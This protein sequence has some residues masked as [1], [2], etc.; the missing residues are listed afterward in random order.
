MPSTISA[1]SPNKKRRR[2][3]KTVT[4]TPLAL[5][6]VTA[7]VAPE[8]AL[9]FLDALQS[10]PEQTA[11]QPV[12]ASPPT[13]LTGATTQE[14]LPD[15]RET[16]L[17]ESSDPD[18]EIIFA[19]DAELAHAELLLEK[20]KLAL[21]ARS[22]AL[23]AAQDVF[24]KQLRIKEIHQEL[25]AS[26][27]KMAQV[28]SAEAE[29]LASAQAKAKE[30]KEF[31]A[32]QVAAAALLASQ[33]KSR[34]EAEATK[35]QKELLG[36]AQR[37]GAESVNSPGKS[38]DQKAPVN[39]NNSIINS[40]MNGLVDDSVGKTIVNP[41]SV[42]PLNAKDLPD[43]LT[44]VIKSA[45]ET[46]EDKNPP[47]VVKETTIPAPAVKE[48]TIP[49]PVN[50]SGPALPATVTNPDIFKAGLA[51]KQDVLF[52]SDKAILSDFVAVEAAFVSIELADCLV[53]QFKAGNSVVQSRL[54]KVRGLSNIPKDLLSVE[55]KLA[56]LTA[57]FCCSTLFQR[58]MN[59]PRALAS[60]NCFL[61]V[62]R[63]HFSW[64]DETSSGHK[65]PPL[66]PFP[67][68]LSGRDL[69]ILF[70]QFIM[71]INCIDVVFGISLSLL[72]KTADEILVLGHS[73]LLVAKYIDDIRQS[74]FANE[75]VTLMW[76]FQDAVFT[77]S[78]NSLAA[79]MPGLIP[80]A[81]VA[82]V[83]PVVIPE[84][85]DFMARRRLNG[86]GRGRQVSAL[87]TEVAHVR[88]PSLR[89]GSIDPNQ[90]WWACNDFND[91]S[92]CGFPSN[93]CKYHH[94]C[95][96]CADPN[97]GLSTHGMVNPKGVTFETQK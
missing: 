10:L 77:Q 96:A 72:Y 30:V 92:G 81:A 87:P 14:N 73:P 34:L 63:G 79:S 29:F 2:N 44:P 43:G 16:T 56:K 25:L 12:V 23:S 42:T 51:T 86:K 9:K 54:T 80:K 89:N 68:N 75:N 15:Q 13:G 52:L 27:A 5:P 53:T 84:V 57:S 4:G 50:G 59:N 20:A 41:G 70:H 47:P 93:V 49:A 8:E 76:S 32:S 61:A 83:I 69:L 26:Q 71:L 33:V 31:E 66:L 24:A 62:N 64:V 94:I 67:A 6:I 60:L 19:V 82:P 11:V 95:S 3:S 65:K 90:K 22:S 35:A 38:G 18:A 85:P 88:T 17:V 1:A 7:T 48:I 91:R 46:L 58:M 97:H 21:E 37:S 40:V 74:V 36:K 55:M 39:L 78:M 28:E 45:A